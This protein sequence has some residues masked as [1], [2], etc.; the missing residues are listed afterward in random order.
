TVSNVGYDI[1]T[2]TVELEFDKEFAGSNAEV[3]MT[4]SFSEGLSESSLPA[5]DLS[6]I[7]SSGSPTGDLIGE[8]FDTQIN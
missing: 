2:P 3:I 8:R 7:Y 5:F 6:Y 4:A 1:T